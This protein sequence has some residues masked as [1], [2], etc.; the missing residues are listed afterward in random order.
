MQETDLRL[1]PNEASDLTP[2]GHEDARRRLGWDR[3]FATVLDEAPAEG[4]IAVIGH[5]A[6]A[7]LSRAWYAR[8]IRG[9]GGSSAGKTQDAE[10]CACHDGWFYVLGS[11]FGSKDGPLDARRSWIARVREK[12]LLTAVRKDS[13][14]T[15]EI[16]RLRFGLHRAVNDALATAGT[17]LWPLGPL[18]R[19]RYIDATIALGARRD[20]RWAGRVT[21]AD[22][23]INVEGAAFR[24]NGTLLLGLRHPVSADGH[25]LLVELD[26][27]GTLFTQP[28]A[29][30]DC[31][32]VWALEGIGTRHEP[33][34]VRALHT[35]GGDRYHAIVGSLEASGKE[36]TLLEDH[37]EAGLATSTHVR[38]EL[39]ANSRGGAVETDVV[40]RFEGEHG[41]EGLATS[42]DGHDTHYV[43]D[44]E[45]QVA[46]RTLIVE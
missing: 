17:D 27:V 28:D 30:P 16:V 44:Q 10:A 46:L 20:K 33:V 22:L 31:R 11:Q 2:L 39:P 34:G 29:I 18:T 4:S 1:E 36:A 45:G 15:L 35:A 24:P 12:A 6:G 14:V 25:A 3:A 9:K 38:F 19:E 8:R 21:S 32:H 41:V 43:I 42:G 5:Q 40:R 13:K 7:S 37:P 23:P 26:D